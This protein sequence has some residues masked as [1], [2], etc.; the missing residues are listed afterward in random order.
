M[1]EMVAYPDM[2][3]VEFTL[4][5]NQISRSF[6]ILQPFDPVPCSSTVTQNLAFVM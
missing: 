5:K 3:T 1:L 6:L 4:P 2:E